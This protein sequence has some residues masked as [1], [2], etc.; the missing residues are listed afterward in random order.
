MT[1]LVYKKYNS[2][3]SLFEGDRTKFKNVCK[4]VDGRWLKEKGWV[5]PNSNSETF[6]KLLSI[7][8]SDVELVEAL[9]EVTVKE[10]PQEV[11]V[12]EEP[13]SP[14][15]AASPTGEE[16]GEFVPNPVMSEESVHTIHR[17]R[18]A[19]S[20][21]RRSRIKPRG[22]K[23]LLDDTDIALSSSSEEDSGD[24]SSPDYPARSPSRKGYINNAAIQKM[25][26]ANRR[27]LELEI[28]DRR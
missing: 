2:K 1:T 20:S 5:I 13:P 4:Q 18:S 7:A 21:A 12:K 16:D 23:V 3:Y 26:M 25:N 28:G 9:P 14:T 15:G 11:T 22:R 8:F 27:L 6:T 17:A 19:K 24:D 10:E